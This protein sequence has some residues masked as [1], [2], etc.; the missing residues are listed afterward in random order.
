MLLNIITS[1]PGGL[2]SIVMSM[3]VCLFVGASSRIT[4]NLHGQ[5]S[6]VLC[7]LP[8]AVA[9]SFSDGIAMLCTS[10]FMTSYFHTMGPMVCIKHDIM[11]RR[12]S[13]G[14]GTI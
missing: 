7:M 2:Q 5:T 3:S 4:Q 12:S 13:P 1:P 11:F 10:G 6:P 9:L 8:V 14:G